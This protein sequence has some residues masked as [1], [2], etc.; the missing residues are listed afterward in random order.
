MSPIEFQAFLQNNKEQFFNKFRTPNKGARGVWK[1]AARH[2]ANAIE[3]N[4]Y[5]PDTFLN[6]KAKIE[7]Y[8]TA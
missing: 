2:A 3:D 1:S 7:S 8:L 5:N 4:D 6:F